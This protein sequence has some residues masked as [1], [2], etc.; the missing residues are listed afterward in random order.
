[1][2]TQKGRLEIGLGKPVQWIDMQCPDN[3]PLCPVIPYLNISNKKQMWYDIL[4]NIQ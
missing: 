3:P 1:M 4:S 2:T